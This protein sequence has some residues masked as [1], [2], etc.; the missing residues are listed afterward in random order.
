MVSGANTTFQILGN[1]IYFLSYRKV[2]MDD[3]GKDDD[4]YFED[5]YNS[6]L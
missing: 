6:F 5:D 3:D 1:V 4:D 2:I